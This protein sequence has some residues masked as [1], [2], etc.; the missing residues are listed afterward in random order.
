MAQQW[1][2]VDRAD[3]ITTITLNR[4]EVMN[5][6]HAE[7]RREVSD[8]LQAADRDEAIRAIILT[9]AGDQAFCAG[10]DLMEA[11]SFAGGADAHVWLDGWTK[12][13]EVIRNL[14]KPLVAALNG[15]AAGSAFQVSIMADVRV[16]H[17]GVRMGQPEI[18]SGIP[19]TL[20]PWLM[21]DRIGL[22][23]TVELT[24][25]G[26]MMDADECKSIGLIHYMVPQVDVM[27]KAREIAALLASKAPGA[28]KANKERFKQ[29]TEAGFREALSAGNLMQEKAFAS[30]EP[31]AYM[32]EFFKARAK[33]A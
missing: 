28:M 6:W 17:A 14:T 26:R 3:G 23:R 11:K 9:G 12:F 24:L 7:M 13:Y 33:R 25:T 15:V 19:S 5:A 27:K 22:S 29:I 30:G 10:Q 18:N 1:I 8:A 31:Q 20:G 2:I 21:E 4:P 16:G 32:E